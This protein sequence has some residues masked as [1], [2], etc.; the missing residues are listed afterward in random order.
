MKGII[1]NIEKSAVKMKDGTMKE[2]F[3]IQFEGDEKSYEAWSCA[4]KVGDEA[5]GEVSEREWNGKIF[6]SIKFAGGFKG[7][8]GF[9]ARGKSPEEIALEREK[10]KQQV[11]SFSASYSKDITVSLIN[12]GKLPTS[13]EIDATLQHYYLFFKGILEA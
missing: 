12:Q 11:R 13:K 8:G 5:E 1:S 10:L 6:H 3:T 2:K 7:G 4:F 9:Q